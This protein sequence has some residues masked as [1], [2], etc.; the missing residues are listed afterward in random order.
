MR[1]RERVREREREGGREKGCECD[2]CMKE[3]KREGDRI[4]RE[5]VRVCMCGSHKAIHE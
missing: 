2:T 3:I 1:V 4:N 5:R